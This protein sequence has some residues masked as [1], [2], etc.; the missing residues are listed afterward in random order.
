M[1]TGKL[2]FAQAMAHLPLHEL[3]RSVARYRGHYKVKRFSC[4]DQF[5]CMAFAQL[6]YR[7]SLRDIE[8][9]L[10]AQHAKLCH[11]G[12]RAHV[13]RSTLAK[14]NEIRDWRI[15]A[16]FAQALIRIARR[17]Y[18]GEEFGVPLKGR[19]TVWTTADLRPRRRAY[20]A[21]INL[22]THNATLFESTRD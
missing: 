3:R 14:A 2:V 4:L 1:H 8:T 22:R 9:C 21:A 10:H 5:L 17:L 13:A 16:D 20:G 19:I 18:A 15:H 7:E 6:T 11:M 12:F